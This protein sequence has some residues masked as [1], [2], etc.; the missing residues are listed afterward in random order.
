MTVSLFT[1]GHSTH[2]VE[3]FLALLAGAGVQAVI[4]VRTVPQSRR[5]PHFNEAALTESLRAAGLSYVF[6]GKELGG[7]P[8][9]LALYTDG[10]A[11]FEKMARSATFRDGLEQVIAGAREH[12][13]ALMCSEKHP[14]DCHRCLL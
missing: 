4:D 2:S 12:H 10:I 11:D 14:L 5:F 13:I 3:R 9:D 7:R 8:A 1:I 6:L